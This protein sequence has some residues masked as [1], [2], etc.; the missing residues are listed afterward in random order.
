[1]RRYEPYF[2]QDC[3]RSPVILLA[4]QVLRRYLIQAESLSCHHSVE[5]C[6]KL[7]IIL[8]AMIG[9]AAGALH[10]WHNR[11][12]LVKA[13]LYSEAFSLTSQIKLRVADHYVRHGTMPSD[14][15]DLDLPPARS[16]FG[17]SVKRI[18][19]NRGGV[20]NVDFEDRVGETAMTFTPAV[21]PVSGQ[22]AWNCTS[23]SIDRSVL[24]V[25]RPSCAY[26]PATEA[27]KLMHAIANK[28]LVQVQNLLV[29][30]THPDTVVNGNTPLMLAAKV[31]DSAIVEALLS[32]GAK[33]DNPALSSERRSPLM[34]AITSNNPKVVTLLLSKGAS[35]TRKDHRGKS[36][37]DH[38]VITD[39][40]LGGERFVLMVSARFNPQFAGVGDIATQTVVDE[41]AEEKRLRSLYPEYV[42]AAKS[43]HVQRI[44]SLLLNEGELVSPELVDGIPLKEHIRKPDC[45]D[46]LHAHLRTKDSYQRAARANLASQVQSC[47]SAGVL[48]ALEETPELDVTGVHAGKSPIDRS[49]TAGCY[50]V[51]RLMVREQQLAGQLDDDIIVN[52]IN[53]AP[54]ATLLKLVG[55]LIAAGANVNGAD[56]NGQSAL[57]TAIAMEQPVVA[58]YLV[59]AGASI[60]QKTSNGSYP[61]IEA[62]KK[63]YEHLV[64]QMVSQGADLNSRDS[65]GRT[66]L[67]AAVGR[68]QQRLVQKLIQAGASTRVTDE[69]GIN[70][71]LLAESRNLKS[72]KTMLVASND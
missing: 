6:V 8:L 22:L 10:S 25:L 59:D 46:V 40:R 57:A 71:I 36:A 31:G 42:G 43:C 17:T 18:A 12:L 49:V 53:Q 63:G 44:R 66:A 14:N 37:M 51:L 30:G 5:N 24:K 21:S 62:T 3:F 64:L 67:F 60:S 35:V 16:L 9:T 15:A 47:D 27:S 19:I 50:A 13:A 41:E 65:L 2:V 54:Q 38:A 32:A 56:S 52:A 26:Q 7:L 39:R 61:V 20:L 69:N 28:D 23:E 72:I 11:G 1:L 68:G 55:S 29:A 45:I 58:K 33:I 4:W 70:P 48:R 34:V